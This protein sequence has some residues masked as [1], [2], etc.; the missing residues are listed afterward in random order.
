LQAWQLGKFAAD[1][2]A[3][4]FKVDDAVKG[5]EF[6]KALGADDLMNCCKQSLEQANL[7]ELPL[8]ELS[9]LVGFRADERKFAYLRHKMIDVDDFAV[10]LSK[11]RKLN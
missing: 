4:L 9:Q 3:G 7:I 10:F 5:Q 8:K 6:L 2:C 1:G 11:T